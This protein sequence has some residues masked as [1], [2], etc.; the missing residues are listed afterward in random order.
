M[1]EDK[2]TVGIVGGAGKMGQCFRKFFER[3]G[4]EVIISDKSSEQDK[5]KDHT[6][7]FIHSNVELANICDII[8]ISVPMDV[9]MD[10]IR[11]VAPHVRKESLLMDLTSLKSNEVNVMLESSQCEVIGAHPVFGPTVSNFRK[12]VMVL[13][14]GRGEKWMPIIR[15]MVE[16]EGALVKVVTPDE[17]D[18]F[19]SVVQGLT[20]FSSISLCN[21]LSNLNIDIE[22]SMKLSS[23]I[24]RLRMGTLGRI[25]FQDPE[26]YADIELRNPK[27]KEIIREYK[28]SVDKL[29]GIIEDN[30][31]Q[32]FIDFFK[33]A[34]SG[35]GDYPKHAQEESD[36]IIDMISKSDEFA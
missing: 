36:K 25:L 31:R 35:L 32:G 8:V 14:P 18:Y 4:H 30:D 7:R 27:I 6:V 9:T 15:D 34:A 16:S 24:Y 28:K 13:C 26:L 2:F 5:F 11:E 23:P 19:M 21:A 12:Q 29:A 33:E 20:H 3:Q 22:D 17:H 1:T 10:V